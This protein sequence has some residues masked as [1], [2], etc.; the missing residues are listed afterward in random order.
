[1]ITKEID[2]GALPLASF[3]LE[4]DNYF[5]APATITFTNTS[6]NADSYTWDFGDGQ[7][8]TEQNPTH[9]YTAPGTYL[10]ELVAKNTFGES[11]TSKEIGVVEATN[12]QSFLEK[13]TKEWHLTSATLDGTDRTS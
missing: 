3:S 13:L 4:S 11:T 7:Q 8:S 9:E 1:Q 6:Q 10:V 12:E 5:Q 2:I